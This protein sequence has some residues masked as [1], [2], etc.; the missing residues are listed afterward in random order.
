MILQWRI[1]KKLTI[2][3]KIRIDWGQ[4]V[5]QIFKTRAINKKRCGRLI[6]SAQNSS[7]LRLAHDF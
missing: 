1:P 6:V 5:D 4:E 7:P 2:R 3:K